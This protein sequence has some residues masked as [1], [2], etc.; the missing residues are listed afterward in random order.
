[1]AKNRLPFLIPCHRVIRG[2]GT[3]GRY[4]GGDDLKRYLLDMEKNGGIRREKSC[5]AV[6]YRTVGETKEFLVEFMGMG[7]ISL[8]KG[9]MEA[10]ET[11]E[12]TALRE[13]GEETGIEVALDTGFRKVST[14]QPEPY[15]VKDV[16]FFVAEYSGGTVVCQETEVRR[17]EFLPLD[18]ALS[19]LTYDS[20]RRILKQA[21]EYLSGK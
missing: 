14:Y 8:P 17:A 2:D 5:G 9:H 1:M 7:H 12:E 21:G 11:E 16:V 13:I 6:V 20:D 4:G 19:L 10:G 3:P 18:E 15:A